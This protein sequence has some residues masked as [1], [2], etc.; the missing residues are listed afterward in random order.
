MGQIILRMLGIEDRRR[1]SI[2]YKS[3]CRKKWKM[4]GKKGKEKSFD[5]GVWHFRT[6][7]VDRITT[8]DELLK[9]CE[10]C[11]NKIRE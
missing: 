9:V 7:H 10:K 8:Q 6:T 4:D 2:M 1:T 11:E 3:L 5:C